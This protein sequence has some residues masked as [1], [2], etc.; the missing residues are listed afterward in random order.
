MRRHDLLRVHMLDRNLPICGHCE[1][2]QTY[3]VTLF[4]DH[5]ISVHICCCGSALAGEEN[6]MM[7]GSGLEGLV[8]LSTYPVRTPYND[9]NNIQPDPGG[10]M[11][12]NACVFN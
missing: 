1:A 11:H 6:P 12:C 10:T 2:V 8:N 7:E 9:N 4:P 5:L 3:V